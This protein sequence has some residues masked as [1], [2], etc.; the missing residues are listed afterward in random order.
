M[1]VRPLL[2][3]DATALDVWFIAQ[4]R[5]AHAAA[6]FLADERVLAVGAFVDGDLVGGA[7]GHVLARPDGPPMALLYDLEVEAAHRRKGIGQALVDAFRGEAERAG[8][9][10]CWVVAEGSNRV[11]TSLYD[12]S[13][14]QREGDR[15][16]YHWVLA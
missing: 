10:T 4:G 16:V 7:W 15:V 1:D 6:A 12:A 9:A 3:D 11:A 14:G 8:C 5:R 13:G 2:A